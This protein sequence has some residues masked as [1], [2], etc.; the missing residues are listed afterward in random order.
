MKRQLGVAA[1][2]SLPTILV[3]GV[4]RKPEVDV[5]EEKGHLLSQKKGL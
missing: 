1:I 4:V 5:T 2:H 3:V